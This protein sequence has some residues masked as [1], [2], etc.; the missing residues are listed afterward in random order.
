MG[1][2]SGDSVTLPRCRV[3]RLR[4]MVA[5]LPSQGPGTD[6]D[7]ERARADLLILVDG[8]SERK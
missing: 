5:F 2:A 7:K 3:A 8:I 1:K 4:A 6:P